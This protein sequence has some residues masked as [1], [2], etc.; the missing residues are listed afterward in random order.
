MRW[1]RSIVLSP[2]DMTL[3][4]STML[5]TN[6]AAHDDLPEGCDDQVIEAEPRNEF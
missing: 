3:I 6:Q 2:G 1:A 4:F 5:R